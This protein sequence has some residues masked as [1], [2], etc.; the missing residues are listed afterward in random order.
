ML[1]ELKIIEVAAENM[2]YTDEEWD[3]DEKEAVEAFYKLAEVRI[4]DIMSARECLLQATEIKNGEVEAEKLK[5]KM[6][7][8]IADKGI[9]YQ[10]K[11]KEMEVPDILSEM[12]MVNIIRHAEAKAEEYLEKLNSDN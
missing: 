12:L 8:F 2:E 3:K 9:E 10:K 11:F 4:R 1:D 5:K 7:K 6:D